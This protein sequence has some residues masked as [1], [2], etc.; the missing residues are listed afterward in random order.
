VTVSNDSSG[1]GPRILLVDD[2]DGFRH[3]LAERLGL[4]GFE[5]VEATSG[6]EA[7]R[8]ARADQ[9][10]DAVVLDCVMPGMDGAATLTELRRYRRDLPVVMLTAHGTVAR[11]ADMG[12][13]GVFRFLTKPVPLAELEAVLRE[14]EP[15][16][17]TPWPGA[18]RR[19]AVRCSRQSAVSGH[20]GGRCRWA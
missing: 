18:T 4:R 17:G 2:E 15:S 9:D 5:V 1:V 8:L 19:Y 20:R 3:S 12:R 13:L 16:V 10:L 7:L 11:A 6:E 14:A